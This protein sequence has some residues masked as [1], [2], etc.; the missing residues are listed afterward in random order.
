[1]LDLGKNFLIAE[2][3]ING[4]QLEKMR[5][6]EDLEFLS[7]HQKLLECEK[8]EIKDVKDWM[9]IDGDTVYTLIMWYSSACERN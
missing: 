7:L 2:Q 4:N 1:M 8:A 6:E 5:D 3:L 9:A